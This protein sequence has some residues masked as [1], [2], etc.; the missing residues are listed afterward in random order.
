MMTFVTTEPRV[1]GGWYMWRRPDGSNALLRY[2]AGD[3]SD[4]EGCLF[5]EE[6]LRGLG[7][8]PVA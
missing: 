3:W 5:S 8:S 6:T 4:E 1:T 2:V 7:W